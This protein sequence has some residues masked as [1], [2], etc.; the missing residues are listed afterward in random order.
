[1]SADLAAFFDRG[2]ARLPESPTLSAWAAAVAPHAQ[3]LMAAPDADWRCGR[4]WFAGVNVLD[5]APDGSVPALGAPP[6]LDTLADD[7]R[8][9][10][11]EAHP[12]ALDRAQL[13]AV[14]PGYPRQD[15]GESDAAHRF[16]R[17]RDAAHVDGLLRAG[18][19]GTE[20]RPAER[21]GFVLGVGVS[22]CGAAGRSPLVIWEG[23]HALMRMALRR[24][25]AAAAPAHWAETDV[26]EAYRAARRTAFETLRRV[27]IDA[28]P[29]EAYLLHR[30]AL[31]GVA[32]WRAAA[33]APRVIAYFRPDPMG[34]DD[35]SWWLEAP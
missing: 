16:R 10:L 22:G 1:M 26:G 17:N 27:E 2:W 5:N 20:R 13:S 9:A 25:L 23:S 12:I 29:G 30:L 18:A 15:P 32:P 34:G 14:R 3:R 24:R 35:P 6:L 7:L 33:E 28:A 8:Q 11:P 4:T 19:S 31:H 21:H